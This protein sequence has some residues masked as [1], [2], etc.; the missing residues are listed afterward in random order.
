MQLIPLTY[1]ARNSKPAMTSSSPSFSA[2]PFSLRLFVL[3]SWLLG[4]LLILDGLTQRLS[5]AYWPA[6][7]WLWPAWA[8]GL[9]LGP[10][11]M[12]WPLLCLGSALLG[13]SFG[14]LGR[15]PWS[16][17][18]ALVSFILALAYAWPGTL[19]AAAG[20]LLLAL[21][22]TRRPDPNH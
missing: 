18:L 7:W 13:A 4:W 10:Q 3:L 22:A 20:L 17:Q 1:N 14:A 8:Q 9:G 11:D 19:L 15:R 12:G 6:G 5:N 21:P 16:H 2:A